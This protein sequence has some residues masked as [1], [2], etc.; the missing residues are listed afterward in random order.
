MNA[1]A[2]YYAVQLARLEAQSARPTAPVVGGRDEPAGATRLVRSAT[3]RVLRSAADRVA[4]Q[5]T[6]SCA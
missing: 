5:T 4:P 1:A 3:A 6:P 2:A